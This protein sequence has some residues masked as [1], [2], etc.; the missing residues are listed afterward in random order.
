M[1]TERLLC[2]A[3]GRACSRSD[4]LVRLLQAQPMRQIRELAIDLYGTADKGNLNKTR[5]LLSQLGHFG[6]LRN[7]G[8][9]RWEVAESAPRL[10]PDGE[11][12]ELRSID[13]ALNVALAPTQIYDPDTDSERPL[14]RGERI[15]HLA[16]RAKPTVPADMR[17]TAMAEQLRSTMARLRLAEEA[18]QRALAERDALR[19]VVSDFMAKVKGL[20]V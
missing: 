8:P 9:G 16:A 1:S 19:N 18:T 3:C 4:Q 15:S 17:M 13:D 7:V 6:K 2:H 20:G 11:G 12:H 14:R 10:A 5:A